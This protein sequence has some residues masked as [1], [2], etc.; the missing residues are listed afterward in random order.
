MKRSAFTLIELLIVIA[1]AV[2]IAGALVPM[3]NTSKQDA[4]VAKLLAL[5]DTLKTA[6]EQYYFDTGEIAQDWPQF[7]THGLS[8]DPGVSGWD[9]PYISKP[10]AIADN[11]FGGTIWLDKEI[12]C[13]DLDGNGDPDRCSYGNAFYFSV[14]SLAICQAIDNAVDKGIP[15]AP[16]ETGSVIFDGS[17]SNYSIIFY[18][19]GGAP[20]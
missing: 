1:I 3:F 4:K 17:G 11:P 5:A 18:L 16:E 10:L 19:F 2:I 12:P 20:Q 14:K 8:S 7:T 6:C 13:F 9:G 15:G